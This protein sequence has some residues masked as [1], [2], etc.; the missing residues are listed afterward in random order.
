MGKGVALPTAPSSVYSNKHV[1]L[2][3]SYSQDC[4]LDQIQ[5]YK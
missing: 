5:V 3:N 2:P 1:L 4:G